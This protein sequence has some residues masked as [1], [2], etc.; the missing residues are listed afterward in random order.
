MT[1]CFALREPIRALWQQACVSPYNR[2]KGSLNEWSK[3]S[4]GG[5]AKTEGT[6]GTGSKEHLSNPSVYLSH[7]LSKGKE[8]W[9]GSRYT[10]AHPYI[11]AK[12]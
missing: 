4:H 7:S 10:H 8:E 6:P 3:F 11:R 2:E 5:R 12:W 9:G 1:C